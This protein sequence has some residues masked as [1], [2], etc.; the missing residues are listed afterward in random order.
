MQKEET[1]FEIYVPAQNNEDLQQALQKI[2]KNVELETLWEVSNKNALERWGITDHG[3]V[4]VQIVANIALKIAR[5]LYED[6]AK[7]SSVEDF[8][9]ADDHAELIVVLASLMHDIGMSI[10]RAHHE[11]YSLFL[12]DKIL[13]QIL[14]FLPERERTIVKSEVLHSIISHGSTGKP[15]TKEA[16]IVRMADALDMKSGRSRIPYEKGKFNIHHLSAIAIKDVQIKKGGKAPVL[17]EI[18]MN[19]SAG[20]FQIDQLLRDKLYGSGIEDYVSVKAFIE[21]EEKSLIKEYDI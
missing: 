13:A 15:S 6:G 18:T 3:K 16:G 14:D 4:H 8:G 17:I 21:G 12:A 20:I 1:N 2:N 19:N 7:M 11:V 9:L 5:M 10:N